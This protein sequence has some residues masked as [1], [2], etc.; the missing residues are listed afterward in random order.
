MKFVALA[1]TFLALATLGDATISL[2]GG[3]KKSDHSALESR[4]TMKGVI[5]EPSAEDLNLLGKALVASYNDV[6][7]ELGYYLLSGYEITESLGQVCGHLCRDDD[8]KKSQLSV[9]IVTPV[10]QVCGHLCRDD[11][12][13]NLLTTPIKQVCGHLC[14]DD[15]SAM[16]VEHALLEAAFC[17]KIKSSGSKFWMDANECSIVFDAPESKKVTVVDNASSPAVMESHVI[18]HGVLE[19]ASKEDAAIISKALVSSFNALNWESQYSMSAVQIPF[20]V[21]IPEQAAECHPHLLCRDATAKQKALYVT[22]VTPLKQVCGHLCRDDDS[23]STLEEL[24]QVCGHL[25]RDDDSAALSARKELEAAFCEKIKSSTSMNLKSAS[26]CS[27]VMVAET[28][29]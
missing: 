15:D 11:D 23:A 18:L 9:S 16:S 3:S 26:K 8:S 4:V 21:A 7:W 29:N 10:K 19:E 14:R 24:G 27:I 13:N 12:S 5:G 17:N 2:R 25:C 28:T 1:S 20:Q 22:V 6:H